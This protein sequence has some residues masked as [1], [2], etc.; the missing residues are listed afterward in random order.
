[1]KEAGSG[2]VVN[3]TDWGIDRPY[4]DRLAYFAAKGGLQSATMGLAKA[5]GPEVR[6]LAIAPGAILG[7]PDMSAEQEAAARRANLLDRLGGPETVAESVIFAIR[8]EFLTG[9]TLTI[10]GGRSL[11]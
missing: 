3:L 2:V 8:N 7:D 5:L 9:T 6:V 4:A 1:M 11:R 10:D